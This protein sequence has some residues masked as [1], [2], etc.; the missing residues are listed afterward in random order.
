VENL[1]RAVQERAFG[2]ISVVNAVAAWLGSTMAVNLQVNVN[3]EVGEGKVEGLLGYVIERLREQYSLPPIRVTV[4]SPIPQGGGLKSSSAVTV[5][6]IKGISRL[7]DLPLHP[8]YLS[9]KFSREA[10]VSLTG[11]YDDAFASY[12]GG[13]SVTDNARM[14][15]LKHYEPPGGIVFLIV[16]RGGRTTDPKAL[17]AYPSLFRRLFELA[18]Q[19]KVLEAMR[20]NGVAVAEIL[21]YDTTPIEESLRKGALAA[22]ISGNGPS[23]FAACK[24][25]EEGPL[26]DYLSSLGRVLRTEAVP[27][28]G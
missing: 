22:G 26:M 16:P 20:L 27:I 3:I 7:F 15:V 1:H 9:A 23:L 5:A 14:E 17:R 28:D 11:A 18:L 4:N 25:G 13:I 19:G 2:G 24:E 6:L 21:G 10:G 8:P 12:R